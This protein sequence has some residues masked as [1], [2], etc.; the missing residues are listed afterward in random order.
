RET[1]KTGLPRPSE[2]FVFNTRRPVFSDIRVRRAL[3]LL[4]DFEW[5]NRNYFF[6]LYKRDGGFFAGSELSAYGRPA[7]AREQELLKPFADHLPPDILAGIYRRPVPE[8]SGRD[9]MTLR[10]ALALLK[11]AGYELN[12]TVLRQ[13]S[14]GTPLAFEIMVVTSDQER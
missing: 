10:A 3:T 13:R 11:G 14:R 12:G 8:G 9:R 7:D 4:F 1:I 5:I 2:F 6:D